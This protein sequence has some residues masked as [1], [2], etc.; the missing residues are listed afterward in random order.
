[1]LLYLLRHGLAGR[2]TQWKGDDSQRPLTPYGEKR[3]AREARSIRNLNLG[4]G[5]IL[6]SPLLRACQTA[7]IVAE[8]L[9]LEEE[10]VIDDRLAPGLNAERL[11]ALMR[12]HQAESMLL[13]GHEPDLSQTVAA[14]IGGGQI[15]F[16]K[17]ALACIDL[18]EPASLKGKLEWLIPPKVLAW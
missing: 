9:G 11:A 1:M 8:A 15:L 18:P 16:R 4:L 10:V 12:D 2:R 14:L 7:E 13:V 6:T 3:M 17:G 5:L